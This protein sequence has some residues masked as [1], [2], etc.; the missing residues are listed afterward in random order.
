[1][2]GTV[3]PVNTVSASSCLEILIEQD[4]Y[5]IGRWQFN[6]P[7][8]KLLETLT[9]EILECFDGLRITINK[10]KSLKLD[11]D[12]CDDY[13]IKLAEWGR[14]AYQAFF[15]EDRANKILTSRLN[16]TVAPTFVSESMPF[17]WE[18]LFE[19]SESDYE[20]GNPEM[21]WGL[22]YTPARIL[23]PEKDISEYVLEQS[24]PSDMLFCLH[25][26]LLQAHRH[27]K[28]EIERLVRATPGNRF[29][30]LGSSCNLTN[31][32]N[33]DPLGDDLLK[34]L[35]KASHNMLHFAC[36]CK[37][38][39]RGDALMISFIQDEEIA[40]KGLVLELETYKFL[41]RQ[42][43]FLCQPLVFLNA[44]QS[45]GGADELRRTFNLPKVFIQHGAAAVIATACPV[46]DMFAAAFAKVFYEFFLRGMVVMDE[47]GKKIVK[48]MSIGEALR[49]TR[50][51]F[52][53][54]FNNPLGLA[55]GVYSPASYRVGG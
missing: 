37:E 30:L 47:T 19:G 43:K 21:F 33:C 45:A 4:L 12:L 20:R 17:P 23:N 50:W 34:Y 22:R 28:P 8:D 11:A 10:N 13:L 55:Y 25:H 42:G 39:K 40:E 5:S 2:R 35:Y 1:M 46:P 53:K 14:I 27:E 52:L 15:G 18:V 54:E 44:C 6:K 49:A 29:T 9:N 3:S 38:N 16:E 32:R 24:Q 51:Y 36:H 41:L 7:A 26:R 48:I 31:D